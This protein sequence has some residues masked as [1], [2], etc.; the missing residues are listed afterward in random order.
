MRIDDP[1]Y[2]FVAQRS[3]DL[4]NWVSTELEIVDSDS[5]LGPDFKSRS[6]IYEGDAPRIFIRVASQTNN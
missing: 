5:N 1:L 4:Q 6:I 3:T 2:S